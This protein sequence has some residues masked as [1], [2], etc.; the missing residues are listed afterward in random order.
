MLAGYLP[1][2]DDPANPEGDNINLLYKYIVSTPLTFPEYVTPHARDLLKRILVPDPRKRA[3]LFEVARHSWLSEYAHMVSHITSTSTTAEEIQ[4]TPATISKLFADNTSIV[5]LLIATGDPYDVPALNRSAS[6][7]EPTKP[8]TGVSPIGGLSQKHGTIDRAE[9]ASRPQKDAKRRTVQVEYVA[10]QSQTQRG[11]ASPPIIPTATSGGRTR[12]R[13]D[14]GPVEIPPTDGYSPATSAARAQPRASAPQSSMPPP[15]RPG[16]DAP[17]AVSDSTSAFGNMPATSAARPST[18]GSMGGSRLPSRGN[19]Y[20]LPVA[21]QLAPTNAEGR[22]SQPKAKPYI[23]PPLQ[24]SAPGPGEPSIGRPSV[25][26]QRLPSDYQPEVEQQGRTHKR[27]NTVGGIGEKLFGRKNSVREK[28]QEGARLEK[29]QKSY[30]PTSMAGPMS[31]EAGGPRRSTESSRRS[32]SFARKNSEQSGASRSSRRFSFLPAS[33]SMRSFSSAHRDSVSAPTSAY[34]QDQRQPSQIPQSRG[35]SQGG[36]R[37]SGMA[38]GRGESRSPSRSTTNSTIPVLYDSQLDAR[39]SQQNRAAPPTSAPSK[40]NYYTPP[41]TSQS[42]GNL[43][44]AS[45]PE[46]QG[47]YYGNTEPTNTH[48]PQYPQG[49]NSQEPQQQGNEAFKKNRRFADAYE[50]DQRQQH[51]GSSGAARRVMDM[52]RR[53]G[54]ARGGEDR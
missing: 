25:S 53:R 2:D 39:G 36:G 27:S 21:A 13:P 12:A 17:R 49:F 14:D 24:S 35:Q 7:R 30:P 26:N 4:D 37:P 31:N 11:E 6:V 48:R 19:S 1:F 46:Q 52:F 8:S 38:F 45:H 47:Q 42:A 50:T 34:P 15:S 10:P 32:F 20:S 33:F 5:D 3:D 28:Q 41:P 22:F 29:P 40:Q 18:G 44:Y 54:K 9:E 23:S 43:Q 51:A 16:R